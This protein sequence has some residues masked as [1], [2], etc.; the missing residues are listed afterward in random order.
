MSEKTKPDP[1]IFTQQKL[2]D[3]TLIGP[4][5]HFV[6]CVGFYWKIRATYPF[7]SNEFFIR[8]GFKN[9]LCRLKSVFMAH[10]Y[11]VPERTECTS[12]IDIQMSHNGNTF[13]LL[14]H[15][16]F[17]L[18][19]RFFFPFL[20]PHKKRNYH[21]LYVQHYNKRQRINHHR[22]HRGEKQNE[23]LSLDKPRH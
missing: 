17:S 8:L 19:S 12:I 20:P 7:C 23:S 14:S 16:I 5:I 21:K 15:F 6:A 22:H 4:N 3:H 10:P 18:N 2:L 13:P 1:C 9:T 11:V